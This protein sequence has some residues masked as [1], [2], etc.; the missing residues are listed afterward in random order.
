MRKIGVLMRT[1]TIAGVLVT[2]LAIGS[3]VAAPK[4]EPP[5]AR[6]L[7]PP[8]H[9]TPKTRQAVKE[10]MGQHAVTMESLIRAVVLLDRPRIRVMASRIA[11]EEVVS[12]TPGVRDK[13]PPELPAKFFQ[14]QQQLA[15]TARQL[16]GAAVEGGD[17]NVLRERFSAL[18]G[19]CVGCHSTYVHD[20]PSPWPADQKGAGGASGSH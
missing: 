8:D 13:K 10:R 20:R 16:A 2:L 1:S 6:V 9:L 5:P 18:A 19:T 11:D 15:A 7:P 12:R 14:E 4:P 17:D 3:V